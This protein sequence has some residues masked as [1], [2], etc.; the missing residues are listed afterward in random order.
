[1][2]IRLESLSLLFAYLLCAP[3]SAQVLPGQWVGDLYSVHLLSNQQYPYGKVLIDENDG[4]REYIPNVA[5][6]GIL[7]VHLDCFGTS[8]DSYWRDGILYTTARGCPERNEDGVEFS[9]LLFAKWEDDE[10]KLLGDY[11][12]YTDNSLEAIPCGGGRFIVRSSNTDLVDDN[13]PDR[14]P[15]CLM[16]IPE[17]KAEA[18]I[19]RSIDHGQDGLREWMSDPNCFKLATYSEV[20]MTD[21]HAVLVNSSTSLYWVFS[22]EKASLVKAGSIFKGVTPDMVTEMGFKQAVLRVNPE[23]SGTVLVAAQEESLFVA[24][25]EDADKEARGLWENVPPEQRYFTGGDYDWIYEFRDRR[26]EVI[27][28]RS[29]LIVWYRIHPE[30]GRVEKLPVPPEGGSS[31]R[32]GGGNDQWRPMP[33]GSVRMGDVDSAL[34][35]RSATD[36]VVLEQGGK[37]QKQAGGA[38]APDAERDSTGL[39]QAGGAATCLVDEEPPLE[40]GG[41]AAPHGV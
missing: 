8:I 39:D 9:R 21:G 26:L 37:G 33:D 27:R 6:S 13:R 12:N 25:K 34:I 15:F 31:F 20:A 5:K 11:K 24:E 38:T 17:G 1:V 22:L 18:R 19:E 29:P 41:G 36:R 4:I 28:E 30:N 35:E 10:W 32:E 14:T 16:R 40:G 7:P 3:V 2:P 23:K